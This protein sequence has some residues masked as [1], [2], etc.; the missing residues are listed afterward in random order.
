VEPT[1]PPTGI[2]A[3]GNIENAIMGRSLEPYH[4]H[5]AGKII[6]LGGGAALIDLLG[7]RIRGRPAWW[8]Y[9]LIYLLKLVGTRNKL[10]AL[11]SLTFN[12]IFEPTV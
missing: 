12:R 7:G 10:Q 3:A 9:R 8:T 2:R 5:H 4:A 11:A 6:S 1:L